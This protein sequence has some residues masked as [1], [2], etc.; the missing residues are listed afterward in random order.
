MLKLIKLLSTLILSMLP[1]LTLVF[2]TA[3]CPFHDMDDIYHESPFPFTTLLL[4]FCFLCSLPVISSSL[5]SRISWIRDDC[6]LLLWLSD[7]IVVKLLFFLIPYPSPYWFFDNQSVT[8]Q[9]FNQIGRNTLQ[10]YLRKPLPITVVIVVP[11]ILYLP[12][13]QLYPL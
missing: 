2:F 5:S 6:L 7:F 8:F 12:W 3:F 13:S 1:L 11:L 10:S 4:V 9:V